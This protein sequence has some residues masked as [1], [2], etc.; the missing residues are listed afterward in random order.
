[1]TIE[2][3][4]NEAERELGFS[5]HDFEMALIREIK[6]LRAEVAN[7]AALIHD[8]TCGTLNQPDHSCPPHPLLR[9]DRKLGEP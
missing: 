1:M 4:L 7:Q 3:W 5:G 6:L 2:E 8:T 9:A